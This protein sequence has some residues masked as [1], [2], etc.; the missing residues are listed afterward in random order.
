MAVRSPA[1]AEL[2]WPNPDAQGGPEDVTVG[3]AYAELQAATSGFP[4]NASRIRIAVRPLDGDIRVS[5]KDSGD[6]WLVK[7]DEVQQ[8]SGVP[9]YAKRDGGSDV[10]VNVWELGPE[11]DVQ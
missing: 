5:F 8:F 2:G 7:Q 3:A 9:L 11:K 4:S 10:S 1:E 6:G